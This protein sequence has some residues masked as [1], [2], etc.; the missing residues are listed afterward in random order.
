MTD[1]GL[2]PVTPHYEPAE[3]EHGWDEWAVLPEQP[4]PHTLHYADGRFYVGCGDWTANL[5]PTDLVSVALDGTVTTHYT[6]VPTDALNNFRLIGGAIYAPYTDPRGPDRGGYVTNAGGSWRVVEF[7]STL[8]VHCFDMGQTSHGLWMTG[9]AHR[10]DS[11]TVPVVL[12]STDDGETWTEMHAGERGPSARYYGLHIQG[13]QP[14]VQAR[15]DTP[16][17]TTTDGGATWVE[18]EAAVPPITSA[19]YAYP[20]AYRAL[21]P[22]PEQQALREWGVMLPPGG[23]RPIVVGEYAYVAGTSGSGWAIYRTDAPERMQQQ[24]RQ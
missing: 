4:G 13:D 17:L 14:Y 6:D 15:H 7:T 5:G 18:S 20:E 1:D 11:T 24:E 8:M 23:V 10:E 2:V 12:L 22:T 19:G 21:N 3:G 9:S 16:L